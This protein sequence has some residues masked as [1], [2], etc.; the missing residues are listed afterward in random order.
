MVPFVT[1][2]AA[3]STMRLSRHL[4]KA[5]CSRVT[6]EAQVQWPLTG[7]ARDCRFID[8][9]MLAALAPHSRLSRWPPLLGV[10]RL[11]RLLE[12]ATW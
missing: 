2:R 9:A 12:A 1:T 6:G 10:P 4:H 8:A 11:L 5:W 7:R 3:S